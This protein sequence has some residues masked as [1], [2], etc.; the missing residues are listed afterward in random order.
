MNVDTAV[1]FGI[2][3]LPHV[4]WSDWFMLAVSGFAAGGVLWICIGAVI[5]WREE[6]RDHWFFA[7]LLLSI[8]STWGIVDYIIKP[9]VGRVRPALLP[10]AILVGTLPGQFSF[11]SGHAAT[12]FAAAEIIASKDVRLRIPIFCLATLVCFSRVYL[13]H[14]YPTDVIAGAIFGWGIGKGIYMIDRQI[15]AM[16][17]Q[18]TVSSTTIKTKKRAT[19]V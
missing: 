11:P 10:G 8:G 9:L 6:V 19:I 7:P 5:V 15:R 2:N 4:W 12:A 18:K 13:G 16:I 14:H 3:H 1:F 17:I